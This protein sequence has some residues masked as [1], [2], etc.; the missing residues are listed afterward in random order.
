MIPC[1]WC[2]NHILTAKTITIGEGAEKYEQA[3]EP[4]SCSECGAREICIYSIAQG[5]R[6]NYEERSKG[7]YENV[8]RG[9]R[10][11]DN[12]LERRKPRRRPRS[13]WIYTKDENDFD[14]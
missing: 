4:Y 14:K 12:T 1:P 9:H 13:G 3:I 6:P 8:H 10:S 5:M 7:F 11:K 2:G